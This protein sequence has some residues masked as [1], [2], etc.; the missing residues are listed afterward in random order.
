MPSEHKDISSNDPDHVAGNNGVDDSSIAASEFPSALEQGQRTIDSYSKHGGE[1]VIPAHSLSSH[2]EGQTI[3]FSMNLQALGGYLVNLGDEIERNDQIYD[4]CL[5]PEQQAATTPEAIVDTGV[6]FTHAGLAL[7]VNGNELERALPPNRIEPSYI[8]ATVNDG[9]LTEVD[10]DWKVLA[11]TLHSYHDL[12]E[13]VR[14]DINQGLDE[15]L[16]PTLPTNPVKTLA[17]SIDAHLNSESKDKFIP[18]QVL[19]EVP[20]YW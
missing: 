5:S 13:R 7:A 14:P 20:V 15:V 17:D 10:V 18:A 1:Q 16:E 3:E 12:I 9:K 6:E 19:Q 2:F 11:S 8:K 4:E